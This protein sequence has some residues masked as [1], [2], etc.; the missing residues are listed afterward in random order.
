MKKILLALLLLP[1]ATFSQTNNTEQDDVSKICL[2]AFIAPQVEALPD[3][4]SSQ[5]TEKINQIVSQ[6]GLGG[7]GFEDRFLLAA[8][9]SVTSKNITSTTPA[10][11]ALD[12]ELSLTI[13]DGLLGTK[14][15]NTILNL[16]GV[17]ANETKAYIDAIKQI[18]S[19]DNNLKNLLDNGKAKIIAYY[20]ANCSTLMQEVKGLEN[21]KKY[22]EAIY[23][24]MAIPKISSE[25]YS[26][27][28]VQIEL[29]YKKMSER[30]CKAKLNEGE[31]IWSAKPTIEGANEVASILGRIDPETECYKSAKIMLSKIY[32][33]VNTQMK[34]VDKREWELRLMKVKSSIEIQK[35]SLKNAREIAIAYASNQPKIIYKTSG[36]W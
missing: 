11:Y 21:Q 34:E 14:F 32:Q 6:N 18:K 30:D 20:K 12:L 1:F 4:V 8:N 5:L 25:C 15:S 19:T 22:E 16:K 17:G 31:A 9:L 24:L 2:K 10:L 35:E 33:T 27:A 36:W 3:I 26:L 29:I 13:G 7:S 23:K 28:V